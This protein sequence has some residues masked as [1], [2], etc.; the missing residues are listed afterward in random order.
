[1]ACRHAGF[2]PGAAVKIHGHSPLMWH[3]CPF[4]NNL[5]DG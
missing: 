3:V 2:A 1:V 4:N 5:G